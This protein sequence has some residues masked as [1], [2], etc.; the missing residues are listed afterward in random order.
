MLLFN[1]SFYC[2][3]VNLEKQSLVDENAELSMGKKGDKSYFA[4]LKR[5]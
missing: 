2:V 5:S 1:E 4:I 3:T